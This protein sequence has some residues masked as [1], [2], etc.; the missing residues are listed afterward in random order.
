MKFAAV[1]K[2]FGIPNLASVNLKRS[3]PS[4]LCYSALGTDGV[5]RKWG[6]DGF[7][8]VAEMIT[9]LIRFEP[10]LCICN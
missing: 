4:P 6:R 7:T 9:E 8:V 5:R 2:A 1:L 10:E 3:S